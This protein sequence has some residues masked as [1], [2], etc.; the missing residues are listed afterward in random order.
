M[1]SFYFGEGFF[2]FR[3]FGKGILVTDRS[4]HKPPFSVRNGYVKEFRIG[5]WGVKYLK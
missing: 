4:L 2:W 3:V 5:K 1:I